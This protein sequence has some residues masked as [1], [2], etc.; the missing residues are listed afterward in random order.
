M[1]WTGGKGKEVQRR[2][3]REGVTGKEVSI[4]KK[5]QERRYTEEGQGKK[6]QE[7]GTGQEVKERKYRKQ[8]QERYREKCKG[9][10]V[11]EWRYRT[12]G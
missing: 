11:N 3:H 8:V 1:S 5:V 10:E 4:G 6:V 12:G 9:K 7:E 2:W